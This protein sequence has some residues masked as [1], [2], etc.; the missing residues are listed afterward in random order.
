MT[1]TGD[2]AF[3]TSS[4]FPNRK[5]GMTYM[6]DTPIL[7]HGPSLSDKLIDQ[8]TTP[9]YTRRE[10]DIMAAETE[11]KRLP[12]HIAWALGST[13]VV[14]GVALSEYMGSGPIVAVVA[15]AVL[16]LVLALAYESAFP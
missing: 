9:L 12:S 11:T 16:M 7:L 6:P 14:I 13:S 15:T 1:E 4:K 3:G 5:T 2:Q 10:F 8:Y